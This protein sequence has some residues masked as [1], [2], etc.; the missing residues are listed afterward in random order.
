[1]WGTTSSNYNGRRGI[2]L[3]EKKLPKGITL[4]K[5]GLYMGRFKYQNETYTIYGKNIKKIEKELAD[6]RYEVEHGLKGKADNMTLNAWFDVWLND[7]KSK[8]VKESTMIRY[9]DQYNQ[10]LKK[11]LGLKRLAQIKPIVLQRHFNTMATKD[12]STKTISDTYTILYNMF[13]IALQNNLILRNPCEAVI[14]PKTKEK[15]RRVL[16]LSEQAE[17]L[18][19]S[20]GRSCENMVL[21]AF[22]TG[23][24]VGELHGLMWSDV[25]FENREI[26]INKTLVYIR[27]KETGK[28]Y[29]KF[30]TP[31]TKAGVRTI[32][33][34]DE[35]YWALKRQRL[36]LKQMQI[37]ARNWNPEPG[38]EN[39]VFVNITGRPRQGMDFRN[40]LD[41]IEKAINK[42]RKKQA[43][44]NGKE[45]EPIPHFHPHTLRHTFATR[46]FEAGIDAK[47]VQNYLGHASIAITMDLYTHVTEDKART[48]MR[49][50]ER[51]YQR[52][53]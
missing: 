29:F 52:I 14:L 10:Y 31:K 17:V 41:R 34:L 21:V 13:K 43:E 30:Q 45:F 9:T 46:C 24:R 53:V 22:Y 32:P 18:E 42:D 15:E 12:Y 48:E 25:D 2:A 40:D 6:L 23:L 50:L 5:D 37:H 7:Y 28:Y 49:K 3:A 11:E 20:K 4:R 35:V 27:N 26:H 39:L 16:T 19:Y 36:L 47:T 8:T 51:L 1:M 44:Q 38:F 33:M